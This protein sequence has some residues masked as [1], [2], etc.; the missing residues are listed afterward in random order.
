VLPPQHPADFLELQHQL[1]VDCSVRLLQPLQVEVYLAHQ[2]QQAE[3]S[4]VHNHRLQHS[5]PPLPSVVVCL[6]RLLQHLE[7]CLE[8]DLLVAFLVRLHQLLVDFSAPPPQLSRWD[9]ME[10]RLQ[11]HRLHPMLWELLP[12]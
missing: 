10:V 3:A 7:E 4:L 12:T 6:E 8:Q 1:P 9:S 11:Q 5:E 2:L